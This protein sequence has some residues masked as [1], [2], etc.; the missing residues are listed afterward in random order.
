M[1]ALRNVFVASLLALGLAGCGGG[2]A[3]GD[4]SGGGGTTGTPTI[5]V[6]MTD[7]TTGANKTNVS[8]GDPAIITATVK[9]GKL[10]IERALV[11]FTI[12][13]TSLATL[14][15]ATG[16]ALTDAEGV[17]RMRLDAVAINS[18]GATTVNVSTSVTVNGAAT[19]V[20]GS[21]NFAVGVANVTLSNLRAVLPTGTTILSPY[22][23]TSIKVDI[24]GVAATTSVPVSFSSTCVN[25]GKASLTASTNSVNGV[26]T[27]T[28]ED[29]GCGGTDVITA[30]VTGTA[31]SASLQ[32]PVQAPSAAAIQFVS[33]EPTTI[34]IKGT[35]ATGLVESS[36]VTF[37]LVDNN[38][39]PITNQTVV[40]GLTTRSG[41][42]LLDGGASGTI[43][44]QT[45]GSGLVRVSVSSG[46]TP[47]A[48]WVTASHTTGTGAVFQTQSA[49]L[50]ISTGR[51]VQDRFSFA[52]ETWNIEGLYINGVTTEVS[53]IASD[54]VGNPV[55]DG[56]A[57]NFIAAGGQIGT[58][59]LGA[60]ATVNGACTAIFTSAS[61]R[62]TNGRVAITA[63]ALGEES[64]R[65]ANGN[66]VY[67]AGESFQDLG[68]VFLDN[69]FSA[70]WELG[71]QAITFASN[72]T[73]C[74]QTIPGTAAA[75]MKA[76]TCDNV[77]GAAHVR[78]SNIIVLSGNQ[79]F[80]TGGTSSSLGTTC[81]PSTLDFSVYDENNNPLPAGTKLEVSNV[82]D[83]WSAEI[84]SD[85]VPNSQNIGG[86]RHTAIFKY[87]DTA[88]CAA[89]TGWSARVTATTPR[90][91]TS[92]ASAAISVPGAPATPP[93][94]P[95]I[96]AATTPN[97]TTI[98]LT[99]AAGAGGAPTSYTATC[100]TDAGTANHTATG[101]A[102]PMNVTV[103]AADTTAT[104][105]IRASNTA[106][107][108]PDSAAFGPIALP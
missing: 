105:T 19:P 88:A 89:A 15:P 55:P 53:V 64:F 21:I 18:A 51:P 92:T 24:G 91:V 78:Q 76:G 16:T 42:I 11:S 68:E 35:G 26:A 93:G 48:V 47:T 37:K 65:D 57:I 90:G 33:A 14:T 74:T 102:S 43:T 45:D 67:D 83:K 13:D 66:N 82:P 5:T 97:A 17:A 63:Y 94:A 80:I 85:T 39:Q 20:S 3:G 56:T 61:P 23:T 87:T 40:L 98:T 96:S 9:N 2:G 99:F 52:V 101:T 95:T 100:A 62:P 108:S 10:A 104:C 79:I 22:A 70:A 59:S 75:L 107:S 81:Q 29:K 7:P 72:A 25:S 60:C 6:T 73:A 31:V 49:A 103:D 58:T 50:Q 106:G 54:R 30:S 34:V 41:G 8:A 36:T 46:T 32:L 28:Y 77:W 71:E 69:N 38:N 86:T 27:A 12:V 44:K 1:G 84:K 4:G